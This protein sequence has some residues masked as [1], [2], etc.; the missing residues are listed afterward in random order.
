[1]YASM[2][3]ELH[4]P[5]MVNIFGCIGLVSFENAY[6]LKNVAANARG[7]LADPMIEL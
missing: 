6:R 7:A 2:L 5:S 3:T 1:M 4:S